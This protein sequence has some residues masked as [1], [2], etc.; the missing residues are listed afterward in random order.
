[1]RK[2]IL[3]PALAGALL[4]AQAPS[5]EGTWFGTLL[6]G[7]TK[8]RLALHVT[9]GA[10]GALTGT[11]DSLD[12]S[13]MGIAASDV[14]VNGR[15]VVVSFPSIGGSFEGAL[16]ED[17][18]RLAGT[19]KQGA[20]AL[21]LTLEKVEKIPEVRRPQ[22]P[23]KPYP[24]DEEEV[25]YE[26][27]AG[28]VKLAGTLT[29]PRS[30]GP[31]SAVLLLTGSGPQDRNESVMGHKPFLVLADYLTRRGIAVLRADDRGVGGSSGVLVNSTEDDFASDA[32]AGVAL[33]RARKDIDP[34]RIGL[35]G[36]SEGGLVGTLAATRSA[37]VAFL[38][39]M[40]GPGV[41]GDE[42]ILKQVALMQEKAGVPEN[43]ATESKLL[44][45]LKQEKD[46]DA[47]LAK[48]QKADAASAEQ[49]PED[50]RKAK[51]A[52]LRLM[53]T[54]WYRSFIACDPRPLLRQLK[55]P[56]LALNGLLDAQVSPG[57]NLPA[58]EAALKAGG[59]KD[60]TIAPMPGLNHLF[61]KAQTGM[62]NE[63]DEIE[64]T[65]NPAALQKIGDWVVA[66]TAR[67]E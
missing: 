59:N 12:Q 18:K 23:R 50:M 26:N 7:G 49:T 29:L 48:M 31:H 37:D 6:A 55:I 4:L 19:W 46:N 33:L 2:M 35:L 39:L 32:L 10:G 42:I 40:A 54:P 3:F 52:E 22:E 28:G 5:F 65:I 9:A 14:S 63:Y 36:H 61:Q 60:F 30:K 45:I 20:A 53:V 27:K 64:E 58:I 43:T 47:A 24:Y 11:L 62:L 25:A 17:G 66:H 56:V 1:M 8:L 16:S 51:Q 34:A 21:P 41:P 13:A 38:V 67:K 44:A 57:Q 15:S